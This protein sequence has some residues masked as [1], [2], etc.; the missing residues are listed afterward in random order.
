MLSQS[1]SPVLSSVVMTTSHSIHT[2][3][4]DRILV[5]ADMQG[6]RVSHETRNTHSPCNVYCLFSIW[7][8]SLVSCKMRPFLTIPPT[9]WVLILCSLLGYSSAMIMTMIFLNSVSLNDMVSSSFFWISLCFSNFLHNC[10]TKSNRTTTQ[11]H[12]KNE[13]VLLGFSSSWVWSRLRL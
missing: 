11:H 7:G 13:R 2:F 8:K 6:K 4:R 3:K 9:I 12:R 1:S 5:Y 10:F